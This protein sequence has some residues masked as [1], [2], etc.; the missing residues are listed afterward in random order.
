MVRISYIALSSEIEPIIAAN[1]RSALEA[2]M[3]IRRKNL[4]WINQV[5]TNSLIRLR[6]VVQLFSILIHQYTGRID[7]PD[8][9]KTC[10]KLLR[11]LHK[12]I[13]EQRRLQGGPETRLELEWLAT[14]KSM[15]IPSPKAEVYP[16]RL[17]KD[18]IEYLNTTTGFVSTE[19]P[20]NN[21]RT[22]TSMAFIDSRDTSTPTPI[23]LPAHRLQLLLLRRAE[24][25]RAQ[26]VKS[27]NDPPTVKEILEM[28]NNQHR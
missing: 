26:G 8:F 19:V 16:V 7:L 1:N 4:R 9:V 28:R 6:P 17:D 3:H 11:N 5:S 20:S 10:Q 2:W 12:V 24:D 27:I 15:T 22:F 18:K 25:I 21:P 14:A 13:D 23:S